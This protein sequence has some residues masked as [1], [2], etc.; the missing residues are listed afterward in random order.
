MI[1]F[2]FRDSC[3]V[4]ISSCEGRDGGGRV[5]GM[6]KGEWGKG[7]KKGKGKGK[8]RKVK[9]GKERGGGEIKGMERRVNNEND[10]GLQ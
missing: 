3:C 9:E 6:G 2:K 8:T 1:P 7:N 10:V 5:K 4:P